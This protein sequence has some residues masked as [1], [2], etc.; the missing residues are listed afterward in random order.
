MIFV[1]SIMIAEKKHT[2]AQLQET[3]LILSKSDSDSASFHSTYLWVVSVDLR[4]WIQVN[5]EI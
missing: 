1:F 5:P 2:K 3:R 4:Q